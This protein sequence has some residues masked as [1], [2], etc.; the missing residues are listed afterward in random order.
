MKDAKN[1]FLI[2]LAI[3]IILA[4]SFFFIFNLTMVKAKKPAIYLYPEEDSQISVKVNIN[5]KMIK[6]IPKYNEGWNVFVTKEGLIENQFDYL[7]YEAGLRKIEIPKKGWIVKYEDLDSWFEINL[8]KLGLNKKEK[9][10]FKEYWLNMLEK[11]NY[12]EIKLLSEEFLNKNMELIVVPNPDTK[13]RL[14]FLFKPIKESYEIENPK[15]VTPLREGF[16]LVEWGGI[17]LK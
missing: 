4:I 13:I 12:Y 1:W 9:L 17:V 2:A 5:G 7:F 16:T 10:Q 8:E 14:N 6:D 11:S 15:I 3:F